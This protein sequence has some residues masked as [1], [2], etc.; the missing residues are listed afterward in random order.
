M[1]VIQNLFLVV[2][3]LALSYM[4]T[5]KSDEITTQTEVTFAAVEPKDTVQQTPKAVEQKVHDPIKLTQSDK[6]K[7]KSSTKKAKRHTFRDMTYEELATTK[8]RKVKEGDLELAIKYAEKMVP[9]CKDMHELK[10]LILELANLLFK[11]G[12]FEKSGKLY[13][14]FIALYPGNEHIERAYYQAILCTSQGVL[15]AVRDQSK[16]KETLE[17]TKKFL[18]RGDIFTTYKAHVET[19]QKQYYQRLAESEINIATFYSNRGSFKAAQH[20]MNNIRKEYADKLPDLEPQLL[21]LEITFAQTQGNKDLI[22]QKVNEL[23]EK[24]PTYSATIALAQAPQ[25]KSFIQKF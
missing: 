19:I 6:R 3:C 5:I 17:L 2:C 25:A 21:A 24:F 20:R 9:M 22:A 11:A 7:R 18:E 8:D 14:E 23:Q 1:I 13:N 4:G 15:D 12:E 10:D 16:T